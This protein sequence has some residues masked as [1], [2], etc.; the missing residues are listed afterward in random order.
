MAFLKDNAD[1]LAAVT[2]DVYSKFGITVDDTP[3]A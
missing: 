3:A 2:R 1:D